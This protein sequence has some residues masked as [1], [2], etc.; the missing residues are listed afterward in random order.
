MAT[1]PAQ[2]DQLIPK[3][4]R[5]IACQ[6]LLNSKTVVFS[7]FLR[8]KPGQSFFG[9]LLSG[10][11]KW[12][13]R[14][15]VIA[16]SCIYIYRTEMAAKY[17]RASSLFGYD[18]AVR[19]QLS[20]VS[21]TMWTFKVVNSL[22]DREKVFC[23]CASS[24][25]TM[26]QWM[27]CLNK[28]ILTANAALTSGSL[29]H[30]IGLGIQIP[31]GISPIS[32]LS[33]HDKRKIRC[34]IHIPHDIVNDDSEEI[35]Y[36]PVGEPNIQSSIES[37]SSSSSSSSAIEDQ[38]KMPYQSY[39]TR[40]LPPVPGE[41]TAVK[42]GQQKQTP[43]VNDRS[44]TDKT[45]KEPEKSSSG[46]L[47]RCV[48]QPPGI[49]DSDTALGDAMMD[50]KPSPN[51]R[52]NYG[53]SQ[54]QMPSAATNPPTGIGRCSDGGNL[55][56]RPLPKPKPSLPSSPDTEYV[57]CS[58]RTDKFSTPKWS[59]SAQKSVQ[60]DSDTKMQATDEAWIQNPAQN[61][62]A[63][64]IPMKPTKPLQPQPVTP[65]DSF[66][67]SAIASS[68]VPT[69]P[70]RS[71]VPTSPDNGSQSISLPLQERNV[72]PVPPP[73]LTLYDSYISSPDSLESGYDI[74]IMQVDDRTKAEA[75]CMITDAE[76]LSDTT[77]RAAFCTEDVDECTEIMKDIKVEG[78]YLIRNS[79]KKNEK[80][81]VIKTFIPRELS[82]K[83]LL[84]KNEDNQ[85]WM[86]NNSPKFSSLAEMINFYRYNPLPNRT[87]SLSKAFSEF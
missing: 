9:D 83:Y 33:D 42:R 31:S 82:V 22:E 58:A 35:E 60:R 47:Q 81:I 14:F 21:S 26:N 17:E 62:N 63:K 7:G 30:N 15:V 52:K 56:P 73:P 19:E 65:K 28:E 25:E 71:S 2:M 11:K 18:N 64:V 70:P 76:C 78:A 84:S 57:D 87:T 67:S 45:T 24:E 38:P 29:L 54:L 40:E 66:G 46:R 48:P 69:K 77:V 4:I 80:T 1:L 53:S 41:R 79:S 55:K 10:Y 43:S 72:P 50:M 74:H 16:K 44:E 61:S 49:H 86:G 27:S 68:T 37:G 59:S 32:R 13:H 3:P 85:Y 20:G 23:F 12:P 39:Q 34:S 36:E 51:A 75:H 8:K 5:D 6:D